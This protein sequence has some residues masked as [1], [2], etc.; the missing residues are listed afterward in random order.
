[1]PLN[2]IYVLNMWGF[3]SPLEATTPTSYC[4][5]SAKFSFHN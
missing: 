4:T 2:Y 1:M 3:F 5:K